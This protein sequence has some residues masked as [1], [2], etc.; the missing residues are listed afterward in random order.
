MDDVIDRI[1]VEEIADPVAEV[2]GHIAG[3]YTDERSVQIVRSIA[4]LPG[5]PSVRTR[6][7]WRSRCAS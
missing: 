4:R 1:E 2:I 7:G 6:H 3:I 5:G